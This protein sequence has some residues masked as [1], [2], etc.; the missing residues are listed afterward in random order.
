MQLNDAE[1]AFAQTEAGRNAVM[2]N[3]RDAV[4]AIRAGGVHIVTDEMAV[5]RAMARDARKS[6]E[7]AVQSHASR[8]GAATRSIIHLLRYA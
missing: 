3:V 8:D 4:R 1:R 6:I 2:A 5:R 7:D